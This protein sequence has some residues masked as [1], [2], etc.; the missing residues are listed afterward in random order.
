M[1][2]IERIEKRI[3]KR[4]KKL[5]RSKRIKFIRGMHPYHRR[6]ISKE[7]S[8]YSYRTI[9]TRC[10]Y[11]NEPKGDRIIPIYEGEMEPIIIM[12]ESLNRE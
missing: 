1:K 4:L 7:S 8:V 2:R 10:N 6:H 11:F 12:P 5:G 3:Q 9:T